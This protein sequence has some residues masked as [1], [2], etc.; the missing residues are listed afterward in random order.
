MGFRKRIYEIIEVAGPDDTLSHIY[1]VLSMFIIIVSIIPLCLKEPSAG[2][3]EIQ[4]VSGRC[5]YVDS[6]IHN[7]FCDHSSECR[8]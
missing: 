1:D 5:R 8:T 7:D 3:L 6:C 2:W 4:R